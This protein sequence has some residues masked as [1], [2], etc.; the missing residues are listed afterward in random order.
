MRTL[1]KPDGSLPRKTRFVPDWGL[2][3]LLALSFV[4]KLVV[5]LQLK[6]HPLTQADS[7]LDTTAYVTL[8]RRVLGGDLG[9]GP[10]LYY[11]S[12]FY[13]YFLAAILA[14]ADSLTAVRIVQIVMGTA[15]VALIFL[16]ARAWFGERAAWIA[17]ALAAF[18]GLFTFY[19][20]LI[21]QS[22]IDVFLTSAALYVLS[23][24]WYLPAG[25][26]FG[27]QSLNR[28]NVLVAAVLVAV[29]A[30][31]VLRRI[32]P[33]AL[34]AGGLVL[35]LSPVVARNVIVANQ[36]SL[37]SSHG[38]LNLYI[39][40]SERATGFYQ[41]VPG[42][43]PEIA[44][45]EKD[46][47]RIAE[48]AR[49]RP[50]TDAE[51]SGYFVDRA[52]DW[53]KTHPIDAGLLFLKKLA[54]AF[55]AQTLPLP[56]SYPFFAYDERTAL[57]FYAV[58]PGLLVP[59]G[60][61]GLVAGLKR[62]TRDDYLV[63]V[64]FVPAYAIAI[65]IFFIAERYRLPLLVPLAIGSG[66]AIDLAWRTAAARRW[67]PLLTGV[68][69]ATVLFA[70]VNRRFALDDGRWIE[71]LRLAERLVIQERYDEVDKR[72]QWLE[73]RAA[74]PGAGYYGIGTQLLA[75]D[76]ADRALPY[77]ER[78]Y[79]ANPSDV[80]VEYGYGQALRRNGRAGEALPHL[81]RGFDAGIEIPGGGYDYAAALK[82]TGDFAGAVE[83]IRR[84]RPADNGDPEP[85][86]RLGRLAME[87]KAPEAAEPYFRRAAE[88]TPDSAAA[89]QQYG[90]NLLVLNRIEEA[91][92]ELAA[93]NRLDPRD[94]DTLAR[95]AYCELKLR[96]TADAETHARAALAIN[97]ADALA[98]RLLG[99][100]RAGG[101][102]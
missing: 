67:G 77:L 15:S 76:R 98:Q 14:V 95:L 39:G 65:A 90:L 87:A 78:A 82:E 92:R 26:I 96:R 74:R 6:D 43:R 2:F 41:L 28:P 20:V 100:L 91:A 35:G 59:L 34:V 38:G 9:L 23:R 57:R 83:A 86:L 60:I 61:I 4:L 33:A 50:L 54:F 27:L 52:L 99:I 53:M 24:R 21:L 80:W 8:A 70:F 66:F 81:K 19:E 102:P 68:A 12:P 94:A 69:A 63:W 79:R 56:H 1:G 37:V 32:R 10:G 17:A 84:I 5:L 93:A 51:V 49:G 22:S 25:V 3:V 62:S 48:R 36:W 58:G 11:V 75:V 31:V 101:Y 18:T 45:Q 71:G 44:G 47:R 30:V 64:S 97:P 72:A 88:M 73:A 13:I 7:G 29:V 89:R 42:V 46:T 85:W 55:H 16:T 40:N